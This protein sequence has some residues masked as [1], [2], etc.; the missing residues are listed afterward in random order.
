MAS[1]F[2]SVALFFSFLRHDRV[3]V[4]KPGPL[5]CIGCFW[6]SF[7]KGPRMSRLG[8]SI[9]CILRDLTSGACSPF[10]VL[11]GRTNQVTHRVLGAGNTPI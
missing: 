7:A 11:A 4:E 1:T 6:R 5:S 3:L 8:G 2:I 10:V 9:T